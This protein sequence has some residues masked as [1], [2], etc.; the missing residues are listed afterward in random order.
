MIITNFSDSL[1]DVYCFEDAYGL[2][3]AII[4]MQHLLTL[5][6]SG[7][8]VK[9]YDK[10][11]NAGCWDEEEFIVKYL[12]SRG[13]TYIPKPPVIC[14]EKEDRKYTLKRGKEWAKKRNLTIRK[15]KNEETLNDPFE[16]QKKA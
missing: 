3:D 1:E 15:W 12:K 7:Y 10:M 6:V 4:D 13:F 11:W 16:A 9:E 8:R 14:L 5:L 2:M